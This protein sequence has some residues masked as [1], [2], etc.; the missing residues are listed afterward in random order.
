MGRQ[1][2]AALGLPRCQDPAVLL[3]H[4]AAPTTSG[5]FTLTGI[6]TARC[7]EPIDVSLF[8]EWPNADATAVADLVRMTPGETRNFTH[9]VRGPPGAAPTGMRAT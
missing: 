3:T 4:R 8:A 9:A 1:P 6:V 5:T 2:L 7:E